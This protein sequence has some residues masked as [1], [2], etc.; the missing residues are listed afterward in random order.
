MSTLNE[1]EVFTLIRP[2]TSRTTIGAA[3]LVELDLRKG[4]LNYNPSK[5]KEDLDSEHRYRGT[6]FSTFTQRNGEAGTLGMWFFPLSVGTLINGVLS[7][8]NGT[9]TYHEIQHF[10]DSDLGGSQDDGIQLVGCVFNGFSF[11]IERGNTGSAVEVDFEFYQ[12]AFEGLADGSA[13]GSFDG[14]TINPYA[15]TDAYIDFRGDNLTDTWGGD[16]PAVRRLSVQYSNDIELRNF[17]SGA[18]RLNRTWTDHLV[19]NPTLTVEIEVEV[20]DDKYLQYSEGDSLIEGSLRLAFRHPDADVNTTSTDVITV[21]SSG[22]NTFTVLSATGL[23]VGDIVFL[24][25][26]TTEFFATFPIDAI[27][28]NDLDFDLAVSPSYVAMDG[29]SGGPIV[30]ENRAFGLIIPRMTLGATTAPLPNGSVRTVTLTY[31]GSLAVGETALMTA[32]A[33]NDVP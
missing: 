8:T 17:R 13:P 33:K 14:S 28:T 16:N 26:P 24:Y 29:A 7:E 4:G 19:R 1:Y 21:A 11:A 20:D 30:V 12:N 23:A 3:S 10:W 9:V 32:H 6:K 27:A 25:H 18:G 22:V 31:S 2:Q 5:V 15:T